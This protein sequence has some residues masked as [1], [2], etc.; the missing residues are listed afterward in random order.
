LDREHWKY[1]FEGTGIVAI[2]ASLVFVGLQLKQS[3]D[4]A[5]AEAASQLLLDE[6]EWVN[7]VDA[8]REIWI[9][10]NKGEDLSDL[11]MSAYRDLFRIRSSMAFFQYRKF[12]NLGT[13]VEIF[14]ADFATYLHKNPGAWRAWK[15]E[16]SEYEKYRLKLLSD[17]ISGSTVERDRDFDS[18][19]RE[20]VEE[21][22]RLYG[23]KSLP[24]S[25]RQE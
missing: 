4:I 5:G 21:L 18:Q 14:I 24:N 17:D 10:G 8:N 3:Q 2:V 7:L 19:L 20:K 13:N 1:W 6:I 16:D 15:F 25:M 12:E 9:K 23:R 11:E 22:D